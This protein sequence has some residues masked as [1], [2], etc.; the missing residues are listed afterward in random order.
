MKITQEIRDY[1][2]SIGTSEE[3]AIAIGMQRKSR[4]FIEKAR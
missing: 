2:A 1:A 4:E 3:E